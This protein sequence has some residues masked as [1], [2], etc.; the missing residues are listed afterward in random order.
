MG[1][2]INERINQ[3]CQENYGGVISTMA[4]DIGIKPTTLRDILSGKVKPSYDTLVLILN[5]DIMGVNPGWLLLGEGEMYRRNSPV[6]II[7]SPLYSEK[8]LESQD[9][10]LYDINAAAN[11]RTLMSDK[12]E[13]IIGK[14]SIPNLPKCDGAIFVKGD[15]MYP[16]L[17]T[18]D[19]V[20]YKEVHNLQYIIYGEIYLVSFD[21]D[22]EEFLTVKYVNKSQQEG[23]IRLVSYN[24]HHEAME[25]PIASIY[26]MALVKVSI[27]MNTIN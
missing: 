19:I 1:T 8:K 17:K 5:A 2:T 10:N 23:Y 25:I 14:I 27:R 12:R 26:A 24:A 4:S 13:N 9:I 11:L 7:N 18:G 22:G 20:V 16:L 15:S 21:L 3:I 6:Q